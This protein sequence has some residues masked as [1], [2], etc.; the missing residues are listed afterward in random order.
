MTMAVGQFALLFTA[1]HIGMP[2]GLASLVLQSQS[3]FTLLLAAWWLRESWQGNQMA[4]LVLAGAGLVL[5]GSAHGASMPLASFGLTVAAAALWGCGNVATRAVG[6]YGPMNQFAFHRVVQPGGAPALLA[7]AV[8]M[9]GASAPCWPLC[10]TSHSPHW[11]RWGASPGYRPCSGL[12][13]GPSSCPLPREPRG[14]V[15]AAE[16]RGGL[17][18]GW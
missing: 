5:I 13:C 15:H 10:K 14:S 3:F 2:S 16:Q 6:R 1:I 8:W 4:G 11:R 9:D 18:T 12:G 7:L 17:T